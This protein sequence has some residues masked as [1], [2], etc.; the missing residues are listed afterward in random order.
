MAK[1]RF[2]QIMTIDF[3]LE[4]VSRRIELKCRIVKPFI[5]LI[6]W[7]LKTE[8]VV[9]TKVDFKWEKEQNDQA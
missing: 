4:P 1:N 2:K 8:I 9:D 6:E 3:E 5:R 7:F